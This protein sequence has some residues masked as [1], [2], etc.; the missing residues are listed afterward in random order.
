MNLDRQAKAV[1]APEGVVGAFW[2]ANKAI[3]LRD[4]WESRARGP[5]GP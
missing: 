4:R 5:G 3:D 1:P 2:V